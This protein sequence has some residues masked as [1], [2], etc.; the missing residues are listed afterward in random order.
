MDRAIT[1]VFWL[2][3]H[4][5]LMVNNQYQRQRDNLIKCDTLQRL[6]ETMIVNCIQTLEIQTK[7]IRISERKLHTMKRIHFKL[8]SQLLTDVQVSLKCML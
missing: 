7:T 3:F 2:T 8:C 1:D 5:Y 4:V 6:E